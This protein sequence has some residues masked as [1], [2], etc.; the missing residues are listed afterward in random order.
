MSNFSSAELTIIGA[1]GAVFLAFLTIHPYRRRLFGWRI[2]AV[3][4]FAFALVMINFTEMVMSRDSGQFTVRTVLF[5]VSAIAGTLLVRSV[6]AEM[7]THRKVK[8]L[9]VRLNRMNRELRRMDEMRSEFV[10]V[11]SHQLRTPVSVIRGYLS[12]IKDGAFGKLEG[13]LQDKMEQI[14]DINERLVLLINNLLNVSRIEKDAAQFWCSEVNL[15]EIIRR[16]VDSMGFRI[17]GKGLTLD[18]VDPE[19]GVPNVFADPERLTEVIVNLIDNAVKYTYSGSVTVSVSEGEDGSSV[20][21]RVKD[22]G[23]GMDPQDMHHVFQKY[24]RP[25]RPTDEHQSGLNLGLGLYVCARFLESMGGK[26]WVE[27]TEPGKGTTVA[28]S[29]PVRPGGVCVPTEGK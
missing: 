16:T 24:Y 9:A 20:I 5:T 26:I 22:T 10:S 21:V 23:I 4:A 6:V 8:A 12:L 18:F 17:R 7:E 28:F 25:H 11:A 1:F 2:A 14:Y 13:D 19:A 15:P 27:S 3:E 29:L